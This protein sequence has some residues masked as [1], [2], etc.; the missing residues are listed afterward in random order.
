MTTASPSIRRLGGRLLWLTA[1]ALLPAVALAQTIANAPTALA[2]TD[3]KAL[4]D[5]R[6]LTRNEKACQNALDWEEKNASL[7]EVAAHIQKQMGQDA[8]SIEVRTTDPLRATFALT[9]APLGKTLNSLA[10]L[11]N[12]R[13]WVFSGGVILGPESVLSEEEVAAIERREG[14]DWMQS[15]VVTGSSAA[16]SGRDAQNRVSMRII[17]T[18][19]KAKLAA[20]GQTEPKAPPPPTAGQPR[21]NLTAPFELPFGELSPATQG[22]LQELLNTQVRLFSGS[23]G[24][25]KPVPPIPPEAFVGFD[26][27][28]PQRV[29]LFVRGMELPAWQTQWDLSF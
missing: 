1:S 5:A 11:A 23:A 14:G 20:K 18:D 15:S 25:D 7:A 10:R 26:D 22:V 29:R 8:P 2:P 24:K 27:T 9:K 17:G 4:D 19:V 12:C 6:A 13:V 3:Q 21:D 16:W 28:R